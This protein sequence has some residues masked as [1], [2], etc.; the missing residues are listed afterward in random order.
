MGNMKKSDNKKDT[1]IPYVHPKSTF[2]Y[3][4]KKIDIKNIR[5]PQYR[6]PLNL[7]IIQNIDKIYVS[8][9][10]KDMLSKNGFVVVN[11]KVKDIAEFYKDAK[12][13]GIPL[14]VTS[15]TLL[16]VYHTFFDA[17]LIELETN[18]FYSML[19]KLL[20]NLLSK[21]EET[22][23]IL[24]ENTLAKEATKLD[25]AY[26]A[27]ALKLLDSETSIPSHVNK[28]VTK[29]LNLILKASNP[30]A[31]SPIFKYKEDYTQYK[32]RGHYT[33]NEKLKKYFRTM[34]WLGRMRFEAIDQE[35]PELA[36]IQ[37]GQALIL[38][39][40]LYTT[41][42]GNSSAFS[43]WEKIYLPVSFIIGKSDDLTFYDYM[44][45]MKK[46]FG[47]FQPHDIDDRDK[48]TRFMEEI[49]KLNKNKILS[50]PIFPREK[51]KV[52][53]LRFMGQRFILDG[54]IHQRLCYPNLPDRFKVSGLDI[55]AALGSD[56][57]F[58]YLEP[59]FKKYSGFK[60][61]LIKIK[62]EVD[63]INETE[64]K[65]TLYM[66][67]LYSIKSLFIKYN[68]GYPIFMQTDA[69]L[70]KNLNTA[71]SS[72]AQLRHDTILYAKQPYAGLT[73]VPPQASDAGFIEPNPILY[74][75]LKNL[76]D[77][78]YNGLL[79]LGLINDKI[80]QKLEHFSY[81]LDKLI[82][83]SLKEL[84][85]ENLN[86]EEYN[87]IKN[88]GYTLEY[89]ITFNETKIKDPRIIVDIYTDPNSMSVLEVGTGYFDKILVAYKKP[90]NKIF[91]GIGLVMSYYE[92]YWPQNNR[93]TDEEWRKLLSS[94]KQPLQFSW[95]NNFKVINP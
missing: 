7:S 15:D 73:A 20:I 23:N 52:I 60:K 6:L 78:T 9:K 3:E 2:I 36:E 33:L 18:Y 92:F 5:S 38:T 93:L 10:A 58:T 53:G 14:F 34:M 44:V 86:E 94:N 12:D 66:G 21:A 91:V 47:K 55:M 46:I 28:L 41:K 45:L 26:I 30:M 42:I 65:S 13:E 89:L 95:I 56:K 57:A 25:L 81:V 8:Q 80:S 11:S 40:L 85:G 90:D 88:F 83:I 76:V 63:C 77:A 37:T 19:E 61:E 24:P 54:Y 51:E 74:H 62:Q 29:E 31:L 43:L 16:F 27:V 59:Q 69:W 48:L 87:F 71:L 75:R 35:K 70:D 1:Q 67:W 49:I 64:W 39:Y 32:P 17:I 4:S 84:H 68:E 72:W 82:A 79:K 50:S 22:Y